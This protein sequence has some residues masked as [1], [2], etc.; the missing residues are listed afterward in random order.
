MKSENLEDKKLG[1]EKDIQRLGFTS[2]RYSL[3][4]KSKDDK[5]EWQRRIDFEDGKYYVYA[6][7]DRESL[8]GNKKEFE[9]F[10][11]AKREFLSRLKG[12]VDLN[13]MYV[14][15]GMSPEYSSPLWDK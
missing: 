14:E 15:A 3:L 9:N 6:L 8:L 10:D 4:N 1:L 2:L 12:A 11:E 13:R 7:A 5:N